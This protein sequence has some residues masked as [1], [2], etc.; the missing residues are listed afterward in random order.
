MTSI[1]G[2]RLAAL[3]PV[4]AGL[5]VVAISETPMRA[6]CAGQIE[7]CYQD[8]AEA[9]GFWSSWAAGLDCEASFIDCVRAGLEY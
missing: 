8:A 5:A 3:L 9:G 6:D 7:A 2:K 4:V 1:V